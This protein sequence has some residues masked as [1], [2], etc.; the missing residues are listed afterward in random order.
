MD[1]QKTPHLVLAHGSTQ[2]RISACTCGQKQGSSSLESK[3]P[4]AVSEA[5][6]NTSQFNPEEPRASLMLSDERFVVSS[7]NNLV[8]SYRRTSTL[9]AEWDS[10]PDSV[11]PAFYA[12]VN[13]Q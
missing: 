9:P 2:N 5:S 4:N 1:L 7:E 11:D 13:R 10:M 8:G 12:G 3:R 6:H